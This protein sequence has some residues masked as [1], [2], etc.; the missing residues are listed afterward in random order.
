M[1]MMVKS[2][3]DFSQQTVSSLNIMFS[4]ISAKLSSTKKGLRFSFLTLGGSTSV[5]NQT[6][7]R[8]RLGVISHVRVMLQERMSLIG[9]TQLRVTKK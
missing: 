4:K 8:D 1:C 5:E 3:S 2:L 6:K 7:A 9:E